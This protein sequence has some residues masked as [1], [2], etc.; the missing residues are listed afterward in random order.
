MVFWTVTPC[1]VVDAYQHFRGMY[2][3]H[4]HGDAM[5]LQSRIPLTSSPLQEPQVSFISLFSVGS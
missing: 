1:G 5:D 4:L 3:L 2:R